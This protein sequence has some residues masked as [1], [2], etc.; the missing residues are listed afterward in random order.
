MPKAI[1]GTSL[2]KYFIT[3]NKN[4]PINKFEIVDFKRIYDNNVTYSNKWMSIED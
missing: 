1:N 2:L 4:C 3:S